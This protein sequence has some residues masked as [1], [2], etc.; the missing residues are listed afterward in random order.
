MRSMMS[1]SASA[2][3][4]GAGAGGGAT[5]ARS[6]SA[7]SSSA[8]AS[9]VESMDR[10][11]ATGAAPIRQRAAGDAATGRDHST[12]GPAIQRVSSPRCGDRRCCDAEVMRREAREGCMRSASTTRTRS[13][14]A[15]TQQ[16][17]GLGSRVGQTAGSYRIVDELGGGGM[18]MVY[19]GEHVLLGRR[20]AVK[21]LRPE[22]G[23]V[24]D[25]VARFFNEARATTSDRH[26][27]IV[28]VFDFGYTD[29]GHA[30]IVMELLDGV[31]LADHVVR[32]RRLPAATVLTLARRIAS[33]LAAAHARGVVHRDLKPD[34]VFLVV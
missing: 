32:S 31:T 1:R 9:C 30:F 17:D 20:A 33:A 3:G 13:S 23:H 5:T 18:G 22:Y 2:A 11:W 8:L 26:P 7:S 28:Q 14:A 24:P 15:A 6:S 10:D 4:T 29:E 16:A 27:G 21:V 34:N 19:V 12:S 25:M